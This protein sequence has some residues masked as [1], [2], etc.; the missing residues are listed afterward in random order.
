MKTREPLQGFIMAA[1]HEVIHL[2]LIFSRVSC[3]FYYRD[4]ACPFQYDLDTSAF[5]IAHTWCFV[6]KMISYVLERY[7][8]YEWANIF[9]VSYVPIYIGV[10]FKA[11]FYELN[12]M[13]V[14]LE[15]C[16]DNKVDLVHEWYT[17]ELRVF[18]GYILA[19]MLFIAVC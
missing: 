17:V 12:T 9:C 4:V 6:S 16:A 10:I 11:H 5:L 7:Q 19:G 3:F 18:Y 2:A 14:H 15:T 1:N 13:V 8:H